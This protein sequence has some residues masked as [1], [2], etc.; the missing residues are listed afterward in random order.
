MLNCKIVSFNILQKLVWTVT[1]G[2]AAAIFSTTVV[3]ADLSTSQARKALTRI[4]GYELK[5]GAVRVKSISGDAA[6]PIVTAE[7]R[8][9]FKF[10]SDAKGKWRV[11]EIR[12]GQDRWESIGRIGA[13]LK[14]NTTAADCNAPD[15]P[16][17]NRIPLDPSP[18]RARCLL[19]DLLGIELPSDA[20]RIQEVAPM[21]IPLASQPSATVIAWL[22]IEARLAR[23][24]SGWRVIEV[25]TGNRDWVVLDS[26]LAS[27]NE[28]KRRQ[29]R[30]ELE[31][32]ASALQK[33][34]KERGYYVVSDSE[35][36]A[37]D[38]LSPRYL[39][40]VIRLDP[41]HQPYK[42]QGERDRFVLSSTG[43]DGKENTPDDIELVS[44]N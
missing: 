29:A 11:A 39:P 24:K 19:G 38:H 40:R 31:L 32:I 20:I 4:A 6:T 18:K 44:S 21:P 42:Y 43:P 7:V 41:W 5:S 28:E 16:T 14:I 36:V 17:R 3:K 2:V 8:T 35:A 26:L 9:I 23:D 10:E 30:S 22:R 25:R 34:R 13:A 27:L 1:I 12:V 15:P 33:F 37:I